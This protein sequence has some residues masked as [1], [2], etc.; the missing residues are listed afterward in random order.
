MDCDAA[1]DEAAT[2]DRP[3]SGNVRGQHECEQMNEP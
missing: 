2:W 1:T 3:G